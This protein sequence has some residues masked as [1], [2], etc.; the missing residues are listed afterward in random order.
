MAVK[1]ER[2]AS[3]ARELE[4]RRDR[5]ENLR[6]RIAL[7]FGQSD[8]QLAQGVRVRAEWG[9][10]LFALDSA[11]VRGPESAPPLP[12]C[13]DVHSGFPVNVDGVR[14]GA[15]E[16]RVCATAL[17][18]NAGYGV[19]GVAWH[20]QYLALALH[21]TTEP[22]IDAAPR[23]ETTGTSLVKVYDVRSSGTPTCTMAAAIRGDLGTVVALAFG[24]AGELACVF[25]GGRAGIVSLTDES[26]SSMRDL[27]TFG[28]APTSVTW[29]GASVVLGFANGYVAEYTCD[30]R[31]KYA[32]PCASSVVAR[33]T[34]G[35]GHVLATSVDGSQSVLDTSDLRLPHK[36]SRLKFY[37]QACTY[38]PLVNSFVYADDQGSARFVPVCFAPDA[39]VADDAGA[40]G[41][42]A[43]H[44][45]EITAVAAA[46]DHPLLLTGC[47]HGSVHVTNAVRKALVSRRQKDGPVECELWRLECAHATSEYRFVDVYAPVAK[48]KV[49]TN[50]LAPFGVCVTGAAWQPG[51]VWVATATASGLV[52][53]DTVDC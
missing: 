3:T 2:E 44:S 32:V 48:V 22:P 28:I 23:I 26:F 41:S 7:F 17:V 18:L 14:L 49:S 42:I 30:L 15:D 9:A 37:S 16:T 29:R 27:P 40:A 45:A 19:L 4:P 24:P 8:A 33:V 46:P 20:A 38:V 36:L 13:G 43:Q 12:P 6:D 31:A 39:D 11:R 53:L 34:A 50:Q 51:G 25:S 1:L 10:Q 47:R 5:S 21:V 52:R 35:P